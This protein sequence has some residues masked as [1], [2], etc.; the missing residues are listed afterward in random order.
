MA[1]FD[2]KVFAQD[3]AVSSQAISTRPEPENICARFSSET[4]SYVVDNIRLADEK[5][6]FFFGASAAIL[7]LVFQ[8]MQPHMVSPLA[9]WPLQ[10]VVGILAMSALGIACLI[11]LGVVTPR[12][13]HGDFGH[14]FFGEIVQF[15]SRDSYVEGV[16]AMPDE[17]LIRE[18]LEHCYDLA[19]ICDQKYRALIW[20][21][22]TLFLGL[23]LAASYFVFLRT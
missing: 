15:E 2:Q 19:K 14:I 8:S 4:H 17:Q 7:Y 16:L 13:G 18:R 21:L 10:R 20:E 22:R 9:A 23:V 1:E 6:A 11:G 12:R 3:Q 5:A